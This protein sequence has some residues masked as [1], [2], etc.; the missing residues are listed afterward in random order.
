MSNK[1]NPEKCGGGV[2]QLAFIRS[3]PHLRQHDRSRVQAPRH[4][5]QIAPLPNSGQE[6]GLATPEPGLLHLG[7]L[8]SHRAAGSAGRPGRRSALGREREEGAVLAWRRVAAAICRVGLRVRA[9]L[10]GAWARSA[11]APAAEPLSPALLAR[12]SGSASRDPECA[13]LPRE[14]AGANGLCGRSCVLL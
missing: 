9:A 10:S 1:V 14:W 8:W 11:A 4:T 13:R 5:P 12:V 3:S 6:G 2:H 7:R